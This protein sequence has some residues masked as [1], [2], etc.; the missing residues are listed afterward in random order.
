MTKKN[1]KQTNEKQK[2]N[3]TMSEP[4]LF[5][6][7]VHRAA[8]LLDICKWLLTDQ[9]QVCS[10]LS[11]M[12]KILTC[13][14]RLFSNLCLRFGIGNKVICYIFR[15]IDH[16]NSTGPNSNDE[17]LAFFLF[18]WS[19]VTVCPALFMSCCCSARR[20]IVQSLCVPRAFLFKAL[21]TVGR[22]K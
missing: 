22:L 2:Q 3:I 10:P 9:N 18:F 13:K 15:G 21:N 8:S 14:G 1:Q 12:A 20:A 4:V 6:M 17:L 19:S 7:C 11:A 16:T 5:D